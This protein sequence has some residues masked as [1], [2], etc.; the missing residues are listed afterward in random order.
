MK[1]KLKTVVQIARH[2]ARTPTKEFFGLLADCE[3]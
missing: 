3:F 2:G 1:E